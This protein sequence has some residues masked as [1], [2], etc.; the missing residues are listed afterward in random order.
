MKPNTEWERL[1]SRPVVDKVLAISFVTVGELL[2]G[3]IKRKWGPA[4]FADLRFRIRNTVVLPYD[5]AL[6]ETY[7]SLKALLYASGRPVTDNDLWIAASAVRHSLPLIS[8]NR[9]HFER[10]PE[11]ILITEHHS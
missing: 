3:A 4:R 9:S 2:F 6:S 11:L 1:Y 10:I 7:A 8:N 5:L